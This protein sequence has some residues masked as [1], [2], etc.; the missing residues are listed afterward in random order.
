MVHDTRIGSSLLAA[1]TLI[2]G[3][4]ASA[5]AA[6]LTRTFAVGVDGCDDAQTTQ[7][8]TPIPTVA[9][10]TDGALKVQFDASL[11]H[12]SSIVAHLLID[13]VEAFASNVLAPGEGTGIQDFGPLP[14]GVHSVGVQA[15]GIPGGCNPG[16]LAVWEGMLSI[17]GRRRC[18]QRRESRTRDPAEVGAL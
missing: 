5:H 1:I 9:L 16:S 17:S 11:S 10:P 8:C 14:A 4:P 6:E 18:P 12:C 3:L 15:E 2:I 7:L 13:G